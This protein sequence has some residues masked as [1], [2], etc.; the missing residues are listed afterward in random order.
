VAGRYGEAS[1]RAIAIKPRDLS[2]FQTTHRLPEGRDQRIP[3]L[4]APFQMHAAE[5][6]HVQHHRFEDRL[7]PETHAPEKGY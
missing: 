7:R 6:H 5:K 1:N 4:L 3:A 2:L